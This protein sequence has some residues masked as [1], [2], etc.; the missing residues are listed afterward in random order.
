MKN[1]NYFVYEHITPD[2]M[3]YFGVTNNIKRR[4][5]GNG[6]HYDTTSLKPY[7]DQY[8]WDNIEHKVLFSNQTKED[9]LKIEDFLIVT[10]TEEGHCIN[11]KRSGHI[12]KEDGYAR[13]QQKK[14]YDR[15]REEWNTYQKE[16]QKEHEY[17]YQKK[18]YDVHRE[19]WNTYL[20]NRYHR[21]KQNKQLKELGYI[22][23]F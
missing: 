15:H 18:Y 2:G 14:Y 3:Y 11:Q 21:K 23:L 1:N 22:P 17:K 9:A 4:W 10:T 7:I 6:S 20:R 13:E 16:Y 19:E 8:G 5:K 12:S